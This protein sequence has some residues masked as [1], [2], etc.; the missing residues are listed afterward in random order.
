MIYRLGYDQI[1]LADPEVKI[2]DDTITA[3]SVMIQYQLFDIESN[4]EILFYG[5]DDQ[6][7]GKKIGYYSDEIGIPHMQLEDVFIS[8]FIE[9]SFDKYSKNR[10]KIITLEEE[11]KKRG[12]RLKY[13]IAEYFKEID[14]NGIS[15]PT[16][17]SEEEFNKIMEENLIKFDN[18][19]NKPTQSTAYE[20]FS[21]LEEIKNEINFK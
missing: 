6:S 20:S 8:N 15:I 10:I 2:E 4:L 19:S 5:E 16:I 11:L 17:I 3:L 9:C 14:K 12:Y 21:I 18:G 13:R 7:I 1:F